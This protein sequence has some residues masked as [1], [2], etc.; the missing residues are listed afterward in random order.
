MDQIYNFLKLKEKV[1]K[2]EPRQILQL[3]KAWNLSEEIRIFMVSLI[4]PIVESFTPDSVGFL[5]CIK[6][7]RY[8]YN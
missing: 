6:L 8:Y 3:E 4:P 7:L 1:S 2:L 5:F